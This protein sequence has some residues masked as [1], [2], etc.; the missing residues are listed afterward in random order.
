MFELIITITFA[1]GGYC[2]YL[3]NEIIGDHI[4]TQEHFEMTE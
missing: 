3:E 4:F 1:D 2:Y